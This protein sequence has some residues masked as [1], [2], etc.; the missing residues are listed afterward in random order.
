MNENLTMEELEGFSCSI[1][2]Q[3]KVELY[4]VA[5]CSHSFCKQCAIGY[6]S[7]QANNFAQ[8]KCLQ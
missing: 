3:E 5:K 2:L 6:I 4:A 1:C 8:A 7:S